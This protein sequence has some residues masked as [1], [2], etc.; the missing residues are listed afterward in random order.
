MY[1]VRIHGR[2]GQGVV[3]AAE[4]LAVAAFS[5][6][7]YAQVV[8]GVGSERAG[9]PVVAFCRI[10]DLPIR[11]REPVLRPEALIVQDPALLR[12]ADVLEGMAPDGYILVNSPHEVDEL[13]LGDLTARRGLLAVHLLTVPAT[14][15]ARRTLGHPLP[16]M[17]LLGAFAAQ[18]GAVT[19]DAVETAVMER[20][21]GRMAEDN[22]EAARTAY[23]FA[24]YVL[25]DHADGVTRV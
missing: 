25:R 18:T 20:F 4:T 12:Q 9:L 23:A 8:P 19:L 7:R 17:A 21:A 2:G 13:G 24:R 6:G 1:A 16:N 5:Q 11:R 3:S 22:I 15:I 14:E 10:D